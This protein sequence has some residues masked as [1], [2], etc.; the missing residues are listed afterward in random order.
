MILL[1]ITIFIYLLDEF[2]QFMKVNINEYKLMSN[3]ILQKYKE[4]FLT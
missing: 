3:E 4:K 1:A 2:A